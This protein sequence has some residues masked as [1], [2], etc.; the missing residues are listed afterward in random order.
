MTAVKSGLMIIDQHRAHVRILYERY[1]QQ[2]KEGKEYAQ[3][4][5]FPELIQ[6]SPAE[7]IIFPKMLPDF[8]AMGF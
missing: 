1:L 8:T 3:K 5:L 7:Q 2:M 4:V 6:L